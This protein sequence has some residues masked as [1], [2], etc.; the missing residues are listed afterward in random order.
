MQTN[1]I[2]K[3][4]ILSKKKLKNINYDVFVVTKVCRKLY[5][6]TLFNGCSVKIKIYKL[7]F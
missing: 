3:I 5:F 2:K 6:L 1:K 4:W 7:I